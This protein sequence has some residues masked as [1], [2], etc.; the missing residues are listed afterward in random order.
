MLNFHYS[1]S[2]SLLIVY[3]NILIWYS[4]PYSTFIS[5]PSYL[6]GGDPGGDCPDAGVVWSD[7]CCGGGIS[8]AWFLYFRNVFHHFLY[9]AQYGIGSSGCSVGDFMFGNFR[10]G[11]FSFSG[12]FHSGSDE[13]SSG[14]YDCLFC[15][16][17]YR[18]C[19]YS[20]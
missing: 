20:V 6:S 18:L 15:I 8:T 13:P 1:L 10:R 12:R 7:S 9:C 2:E 19:G 11:P 17:V 14:L 16:G 4:I 5:M 3:T